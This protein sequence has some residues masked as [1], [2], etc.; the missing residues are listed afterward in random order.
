M[1]SKIFVD[2]G[3]LFGSI[4]MFQCFHFLYHGIILLDFLIFSRYGILYMSFPGHSPIIILFRIV[5]H[6]YN[7][8]VGTNFY[9]SMGCLSGFPMSSL[10]GW[11]Y[12]S[13]ILFCCLDDSFILMVY[14]LI[15]L[16]F[17]VMVSCELVFS[18]TLLFLLFYFLFGMVLFFFPFPIFW[19]G[20][21]FL[22]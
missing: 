8:S 15:S 7:S 13:K 2:N 16:H 4:C 17:Y 10:M 12:S 5:S 21:L 9:L 18:P 6:L 20:Y 14:G 11:F 1:L 19:I 3:F 22:N